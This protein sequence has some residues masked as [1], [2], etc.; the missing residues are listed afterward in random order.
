MLIQ[1][2]TRGQVDKTPA[3]QFKLQQFESSRCQDPREAARHL[4]ASPTSAMEVGGKK[5]KKFS[6]A[7][8]Y[9]IFLRGKIFENRKSSPTIDF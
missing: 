7:K 2:E 8:I 4:V 9:T 5:K 3:Q 1:Q 6:R